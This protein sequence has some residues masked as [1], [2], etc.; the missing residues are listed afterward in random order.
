MRARFD[1]LMRSVLTPEQM[2]KYEQQR[3]SRGQGQR[4]RLG[5]LWVME[6]PKARQPTAHPVRLGL[7]D[8]RYTEIIGDGVKEGDVVVTRS[9]TEQ[10]K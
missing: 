5:T 10:K 9:R 4:V 6:S 1:N 7:A 2:Q 3:S 8:D